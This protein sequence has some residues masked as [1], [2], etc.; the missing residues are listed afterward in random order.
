[1]NTKKMTTAKNW[2]SLEE[3]FSALNEKCNYIVLRNWERLDTPDMFLDGHDDID[4]L[5]E[6]PKLLRKEIGARKE[7]FLGHYD[8][9]WVQLNGKKVEIG[10]R[11]VGDGYYN[12]AWEKAMLDA[13]IKY[14]DFYN[15]MNEENYFYSLMYHALFHKKKVSDDYREKISAMGKTFGY[16]DISSD[17]DM[18]CL[19]LD[20]M[21][22]HNYRITFP[23]DVTIPNMRMRNNKAFQEDTEGELIWKIRRIVTLPKRK[24]RNKLRKLNQRI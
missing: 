24:L 7:S 8:H 18:E 11:Y 20:Y 15:V 22:K 13:K 2:N 21:R 14:K 1:M 23:K 5:C 16:S 9:Y 6:N 17:E 19:T 3:L 10:I 4:I 12:T